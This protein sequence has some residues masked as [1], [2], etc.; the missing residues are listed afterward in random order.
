VTDEPKPPA[1]ADDETSS[2]TGFFVTSDGAIV[3]NAHVVENFYEWRHSSERQ[4][5]H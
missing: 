5:R 3:T 4:L 2:G 1:K